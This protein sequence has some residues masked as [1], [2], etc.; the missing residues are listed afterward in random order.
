MSIA[1]RGVLVTLSLLLLA[2]CKKD[3]MADQPKLGT[4]DVSGV[5]ANGA[6]AR[7]LVAGTVPRDPQRTPGEPYA[8]QW[9][10]GPVGAVHSVPED[11]AIP[12]PVNQTLIHRGQ[13]RFNIYC[14]VC[15]G[16][17]GNGNG[18]IVQ[19]GFIR[20]PS[21]HND[22]LSDPRRTGDGHFYNVIT[23]GYGAM[24][25]YSERVAPEDRWAI[26]AYIRVLQASVKQAHDSGKIS[27]AEYV[28]LQGMRP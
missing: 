26:A 9:E 23:N 7:P 17:L 13:E 4:Y 16:R 6:E 28:G 8:Y 19:R 10:A 22:R 25:S 14:S 5:F 21:F 11:Q 12:I 15:H 20:P 1:L 24:F 3:D 2:G 27:N 18:M